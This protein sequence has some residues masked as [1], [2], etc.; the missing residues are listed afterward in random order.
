MIPGTEALVYVSTSSTSSDGWGLYRVNLDGTDERL[1]FSR[2]VAVPQPAPDGRWV[3]LALGDLSFRRSSAAAVAFIDSETGE[4]AAARVEVPLLP[5]VSSASFGRPR[6]FSDGRFA[7][8]GHVDGRLGILQVEL[9]MT[10]G[11]VAVGVPL[12]GFLA[13]VNVESFDIS[14]D[15]RRVV[16]SYE[17]PTVAL[18]IVDRISALALPRE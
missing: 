14:P 11:E 9:D 1:L 2:S 7:Y 16:I 17:R 12:A 13:D 10:R 8:V 6:W 4:V 18:A 3:A 5:R 15:D